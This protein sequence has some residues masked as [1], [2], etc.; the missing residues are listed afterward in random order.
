MRVFIRYTQN[1]DPTV[2]FTRWG[3]F[4]QRT[5]DAVAQVVKP[6]LQTTGLENIRRYIPKGGDGSV[7]NSLVVLDESDQWHIRM[8]ITTGNPGYKDLLK[9]LEYGTRAHLIMPRVKQALHFQP[10]WMRFYIG[11][12][13]G[14]R[15]V[16][17]SQ[18]L[19]DF[20]FADHVNH[21][22]TA[23]YH[24]FRQGMMDIKPDLDLLVK[25]KIGE[26]KWSG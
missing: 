19:G 3:S 10:V 11:T 1:V 4:S 8:H 24:M 7:A 20:I 13:A 2:V 16:T 17:P 5:R 26:V 12:T 25:S 14:E 9:W 23:A 6:F 18:I 21:P 15:K 22:G